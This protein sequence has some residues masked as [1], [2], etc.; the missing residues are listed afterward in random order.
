MEKQRSTDLAHSR[1]LDPV[2]RD[3]LTARFGRC[4]ET[5]PIGTSGN[6]WLIRS[7]SG[8]II[9]KSL[10][11]ARPM[12]L[13]VPLF[14]QLHQAAI[15]PRLRAVFETQEEWFAAFEF[16][17]GELP[18]QSSESWQSLW[19]Q[20][21]ALLPRLAAITNLQ[22]FD[23]SSYWM[24]VIGSFEFYDAPAESLKR[25]LQASSVPGPFGV[26]HGDFSPQNFVPTAN[27]LLLIDWE[28]AGRASTA[29]DAGWLLV[30]AELGL[31]P[32]RTPSQLIE[33]MEPLGL[34]SN[35]LKWSFRI[36]LLRLFWRAR[37][38]AIDSQGRA[39][40]MTRL[41]ELISRELE[42]AD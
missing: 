35:A 34:D 1:K 24:A 27:G 7:A 25:R 33:A 17:S 38:L 39:A 21:I 23:L 5:R 31:T 40:T 37:T 10:D 12:T 36:G 30:L 9:L 8:I 16:L 22:L 32:Q 2:V 3:E 20:A 41:R 18:P 19:P 26:A 6:T 15:G 29:F 13:L 4:F 11:N 28:S 14:D 42:Q